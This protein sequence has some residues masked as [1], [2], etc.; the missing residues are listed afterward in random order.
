MRTVLI[1]RSREA[2]AYAAD[3][4][5]A[6]ASDGKKNV[7]IFGQGRAGTT[8][9]EQLMC[10]TGQFVGY[11][12]V[13]NTVTRE[14]LWP[15]RFVRGLGR[16]VPGENVILHVKPE[17]LGGA[18]RRPVDERAFLEAMHDDGWTI[19]HIRRADIIRQM[20]SKYIAKARGAYHKTDE[21]EERINLQIPPQE[22]L[23]QYE[24][25]TG[26]LQKEDNILEGLQ[27]LKISYESDLESPERHQRTIDE[28]LDQLGLERRPVS[29]ALKKIT[30]A[31]A[32]DY[33][34]NLNELREA[35]TA[36]GVEWTL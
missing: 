1:L 32:K 34:S 30:T 31:P 3:L 22:F 28:I 9:F 8:L 25:R 17:H 19:V 26:L 7:L 14:V 33:L 35:L 36:R 20:L 4:K 24:R 11:H 18:R 29:T 2:R 27:H 5:G 12:E 10:S 16:W 15:I 23:E 13:L 6:K 21:Q